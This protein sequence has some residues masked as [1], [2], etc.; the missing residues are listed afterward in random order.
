MPKFILTNDPH[1]SHKNPVS[2]IDNYHDAIFGKLEQIL[3]L[4]IKV[5]AS[6]ILIA[7]DIFNEKTRVP[8][9][10]VFEVWSWCIRAKRE[11]IRTIAIP[12]NHDL[13]QDR[14]DSLPGQALGLLF[15]GGAMEDASFKIITVDGVDICGIPYPAAKD[16]SLYSRLPLP[17]S[18]R[19]ILMAH[20]F[21]TLEGGEYFGEPII[22]YPALLSSP[23][24]LFHFGHDH[25]DNG[26]VTIH[27]KC[28][29]NVGALSRG[30]LSHENITRD[31]KCVLVEMLEGDSKITQIRLR[32]GPPG[33]VFDLALRAQKERE[34]DDIEQFVGALSTELTS[35]NAIN[36]KEKIEV[37]DLPA[38]VRQ[39]VN[40][41]I[42]QAEA[43]AQA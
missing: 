4:A 40:F 29:V 16:L 32:F 3:S 33:D 5:K 1:L 8:L 17:S 13:Y 22:P 26:V 12:G 31:V 34:R 23:F 25:R 18:P 14:Y 11:G 19:S 15:L 6:A 38:A 42:E 7:G 2:R 24:N 30:A 20:C 10:L 27:D 9:S 21:A 36:F 37:M 41:Y 43:N 28:F 35:V 39:R